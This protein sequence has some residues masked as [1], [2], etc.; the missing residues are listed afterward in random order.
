MGKKQV[1]MP[2]TQEVLRYLNALSGFGSQ[3]TFL[4]ASTFLRPYMVKFP[5]ILES[6]YV[7]RSNLLNCTHFQWSKTKCG[8]LLHTADTYCI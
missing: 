4:S 1:C 3:Q 5:A 8:S 7:S 2:V 6:Q